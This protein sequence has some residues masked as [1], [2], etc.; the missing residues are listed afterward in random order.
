[1]FE[2]YNKETLEKVKV[3]SVGEDSCGYPKFLIRK[4]NQ[5]IWRS[6]KHFITEEEYWTTVKNGE[7][8]EKLYCQNDGGILSLDERLKN[9]AF[10]KSYLD[11]T[12]PS[13][14]VPTKEEYDNARK[15]FKEFIE[16]VYK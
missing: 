4:D 15:F 11:N 1:M 5:W 10:L 12:A 13:E 2:V 6:A 9:N 3:Y 8:Y 16:F 7:L 14:Y